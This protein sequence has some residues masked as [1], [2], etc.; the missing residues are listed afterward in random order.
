M[1]ASSKPPEDQAE[2]SLEPPG[3]VCRESS[4]PELPTV[5]LPHPA[6]LGALAAALAG[7]ADLHRIHIEAA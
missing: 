1:Q 6:S 4:S 2:L 3:R 5:I 7:V